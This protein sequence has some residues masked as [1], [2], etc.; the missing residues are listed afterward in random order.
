MEKKKEKKTKASFLTEFALAE[1]L[2]RLACVKRFP[3]G[4]ILLTHTYAHCKGKE[5]KGRGK[6]TLRR[7]TGKREIV[8]VVCLS[9]IYVPKAMT[10]T[11]EMRIVS[12]S[13]S[14]CLCVREKDRSKRKSTRKL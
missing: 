3:R 8:C 12:V 14:F 2:W 1:P 10:I 4:I 6:K 9:A 5:R 13:L 11:A 7:E